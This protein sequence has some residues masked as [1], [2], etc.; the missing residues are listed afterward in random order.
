MNKTYN[1]FVELEDQGLTNNNVS[2]RV[3]RIS[4]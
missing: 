1:L 4:Q 3:H 2:D